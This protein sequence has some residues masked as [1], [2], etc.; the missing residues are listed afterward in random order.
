MVRYDIRAY[1]APCAQSEILR[2]SSLEPSANKLLVAPKCPMKTRSIN[3]SQILYDKKSSN[4]G[5]LRA[6]KQLPK[7]EYDE[8]ASQLGQ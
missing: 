1:T 4:V 2:V 5:A 3:S 7:E 6:Q 8:L